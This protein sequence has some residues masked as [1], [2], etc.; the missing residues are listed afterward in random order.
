MEDDKVFFWTSVTLFCFLQIIDKKCVLLLQ[1]LSNVRYTI[2]NL[3]NVLYSNLWFFKRVMFQ[4]SWILWIIFFRQMAT[5]SKSSRKLKSRLIYTD[6]NVFVY[7]S[8]FVRWYNTPSNYYRHQQHQQKQ[9]RKKKARKK[10]EKKCK[11]LKGICINITF[12]TIKCWFL[13]YI[14]C[15]KE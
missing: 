13:N 2:W 9:Q 1:W 3:Y 8:M 15:V 11:P 7:L 6:K 4:I 5:P 12:L 10:E 14:K